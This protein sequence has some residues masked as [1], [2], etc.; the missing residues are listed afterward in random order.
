MPRDTGR[1]QAV[2]VTSQRVIS[3]GGSVLRIAGKR[4]NSWWF[5]NCPQGW[6]CSISMLFIDSRNLR[7]VWMGRDRVPAP[8]LGRDVTH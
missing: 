5:A 3:R 8:A 2:I 6:V 1:V 4:R 7:M